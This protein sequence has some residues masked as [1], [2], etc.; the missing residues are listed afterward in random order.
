MLFLFLLESARN[1]PAE[2][3]VID[4]AKEGL[5]Y[6]QSRACFWKEQE[7]IPARP[8]SY[9]P[10][11]YRSH[12]FA[13]SAHS[14]R[15]SKTPKKSKSFIS[16]QSEDF[17]TTSRENTDFSSGEPTVPRRKEKSTLSREKSNLS[18]EKS[19]LHRENSKVNHDRLSDLSK[20]RVK[21]EKSLTVD[22]SPK[23][24]P[25][26]SPYDHSKE[27][28]PRPKKIHLP[29][30]DDANKVYKM[31]ALPKTPLTQV[32]IDIDREESTL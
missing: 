27:G 24:T 2:R 31:D 32:R 1:N 8:P 3:D 25:S 22:E 6:L 18:K 30:I 11:S 17:G 28:T 14:P 16:S 10:P 19:N 5:G 4:E 23:R 20:P 13:H 12:S 7:P 29:K 9:R 15:A 21:H 26:R